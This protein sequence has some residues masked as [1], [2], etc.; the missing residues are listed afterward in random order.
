[1]ALLAKVLVAL[2]LCVAAGQEGGCID[3]SEQLGANGCMDVSAS[4]FCDEPCFG[5]LNSMRQVCSNETMPTAEQVAQTV[6]LCEPIGDM[7]CMALFN[8]VNTSCGYMVCEYP[9][10]PMMEA[11]AQKC[12]NET[13]LF[14]GE[15]KPIKEQAAFVL[16]SCTNPCLSAFRSL[17]MD[18]DCQSYSNASG[19]GMSWCADACLE[20]IEFLTQNCTW[21]TLTTLT[22]DDNDT[23]VVDFAN[24]VL[25]YCGPCTQK[26]LAMSDGGCYQPADAAMCESCEME[27]DYLLESCNDEYFANYSVATLA[28]GMKYN[29]EYY[30]NKMNMG[31][32][33]MKIDIETANRVGARLC[34]QRRL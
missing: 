32:K 25:S 5:I 31:P 33:C 27:A 24:L 34:P 11:I 28:E 4:S 20:K 17:L 29:A 23:P 30:C 19:T 10:L 26:F 9:C 13:E 22:M 18:R 1:M 7:D 3:L 16:D 2:S 15:A 8:K 12:T 14:D 21:E 6:A